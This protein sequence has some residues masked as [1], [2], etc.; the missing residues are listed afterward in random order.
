MSADEDP[1]ELIKKGNSFEAASDYWRSA[2]YYG[3]SSICLRCRADALATQ[4]CNGNGSRSGVAGVDGGGG[5]DNCS[6]KIENQR[7]ISLYRAQSLEYMYKARHSLLE[8]MRFENDQDRS[9]TL[10]VAKS[11]SGSLDPVCSM[12]SSVDRTKRNRIFELLFSGRCEAFHVGTQSDSLSVEQVGAPNRMNHAASGIA[13]NSSNSVAIDRAVPVVNDLPIQQQQGNP[14]LLATRAQSEGES[15]TMHGH[16]PNHG[17]SEM[18]STEKCSTTSLS[19]PIDDETDYRRQS[20]ESRLAKLDSSLLPKAPYHRKSNSLSG[21]D[22]DS[23]KR[24]NEIRRGL[25]RLGVSLPDST[26]KRELVHKHVTAGDQVKLIIE[27]A[28]DEVRIE[29]GMHMDDHDGGYSN[30]YADEDVHAYNNDDGVDEH[31]SMFEGFEN[32]EYDVD[33]LLTMAENLVA[34]SGTE[35]DGKGGVYSPELMQIKN[36]QALLLEAR[37]CLELDSSTKGGDEQGKDTSDLQG[38]IDNDVQGATATKAAV[39]IKNAHNY[40]Q[41]LLRHFR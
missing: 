33:A 32:K 5:R 18:H 7:I 26:R 41:E 24:V 21:G 10:E 37:L 35:I 36:I 6:T 30:E 22:D 4:L 34:K 16:C 3:R 1:F 38:S 15:S 9:R 12:I 19:T 39:L 25:E 20:I 29:R 28:T 31:D 40:M 27:Q 14:L 17:Y 2:E 8:A 23:D 11:G 13:L